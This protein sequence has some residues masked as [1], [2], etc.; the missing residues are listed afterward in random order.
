M[1]GKTEWLELYNNWATNDNPGFVDEE[2][3]LKGFV[4]NAP[5]FERIRGFEPIAFDKIGCRL[6]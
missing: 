5:V 1:D 2:N 6:K 3:P 4:K